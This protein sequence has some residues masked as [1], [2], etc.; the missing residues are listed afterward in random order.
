MVLS[1]KKIVALF[2]DCS[3]LGGV[4]IQCCTIIITSNNIDSYLIDHPQHTVN[5]SLLHQY[6]LQFSVIRDH[7]ELLVHEGTEFTEVRP[8]FWILTP[9]STHHSK[10]VVLKITYESQLLYAY[11][12]LYNKLVFRLARDL[13]L[14]V[15]SLIQHIYALTYRLVAPYQH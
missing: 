11:I 6:H 8:L 1:E 15:R 3:L 12:Y 5:F 13:W 9:A 2:K 14:K 7:A 10:A 4:R